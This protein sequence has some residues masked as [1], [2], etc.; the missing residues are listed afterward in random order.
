MREENAIRFPYQKEVL[1]RVLG[2]LEN[3]GNYMVQT[4]L[5]QNGRIVPRRT[6]RRLT[7]QELKSP[8]EAKKR[9]TFD[10]DIKKLMGDSIVIVPTPKPDDFELDEFYQ[11]TD[12]TEPP[13]V[14]DEDPVDA[15]GKAV[16]E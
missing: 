8:S 11:D 13:L 2:P 12:G 4:A 7:I 10:V 1:G 3:E 15:T 6:C 16:Y 14:P 5:K 9:A